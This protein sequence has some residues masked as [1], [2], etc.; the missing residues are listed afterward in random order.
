MEERKRLSK[1]IVLFAILLGFC[2]ILISGKNS[3][4]YGAEEGFPL[5]PITVISPFEAGGGTEVELR[6]LSPYVQKHLGQPLVIQSMPGG[7]TTIGTSAA[8]RAKPDGYTIVCNPIPHTI[9]AQELHG[10][11][12]HLENFEY[13][14][15]WFKGSMGPIVKSDSQYKTFS[16]LVEASKK[17]PLKAAIAGIGSIDHLYTLLLEKYTGLKA[18]VVPYEGGGPA[19]TAVIRGDV[20]FFVGLRTTSVRFIRDGKVR[21]LANLGPEPMEALPDTPTIYQL[22]YK[23]FPYIPFVR[24][25]AAP[26][27]TPKDRV[28]ILEEAFKNAVDDP[29]FKETMKKQGRPVVTMAGE[30]LKEFAQYSLKIAKEYMPIMKKK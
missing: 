7:G 11:D 15:S 18:T 6:I 17:K 30:K 23:D 14:Y 26:P 22:G 2:A 1:L 24:G 13:I 5:R 25:V 28:K 12:S 20:D 3:L 29:M 19:T 8:A 10:T 4:I 27:G 16:D 21:E 9:L